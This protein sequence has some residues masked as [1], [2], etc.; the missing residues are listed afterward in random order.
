MDMNNN[1]EEGAHE[2]VIVRHHR[3]DHDEDHHGGVW[4]IAY[5]DFMT[6]MMAFFL[7]MWLI[8]A[9]DKKTVSQIA[10]YFNPLKLSDRVTSKKGVQEMA[11]GEPSVEHKDEKVKN[12][13]ENSEKASAEGEAKPEDHPE[14]T[15]KTLGGK[16]EGSTAD[17]I[18]S[19]Y[20]EQDLFK[21]PYN[22]LS[23]IASKA[24][25]EK[26]KIFGEKRA[27]DEK[28]HGGEAFRDPFDPDFRNAPTKGGQEMAK[29]APNIDPFGGT[30]IPR[31]GAVEG[32][33]AT[34]TPPAPDDS[35]V[36]NK[37]KDSET[38]RLETQLKQAVAGL[39]PGAMPN[40]E[41]RN[42]DEGKVI[43]LTDQ[44]DFGMFNIGSAEPKPELVTVMDK[45]GKI[46]AE[47]SGSVIVRG[48]TDGR[49]FKSGNYDN[50]RLSTARAQMAYHMLVRGGVPE[51]RFEAIQGFADRMLLSPKEPG[52]AQNR[53]IE[54][55]LR[56]VK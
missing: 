25:K 53:R 45:L 41:V 35:S 40:I 34:P 6:A 12:K 55:L 27:P 7:V 28:A 38:T 19:A 39:D 24:P 37:D 13:G 52:A 2:V 3:G 50:W 54:I 33:A 46:I 4:K 15:K 1:K 23:D 17:G 49:P 51:K 26:K 11:P 8:N 42:T 10:N 47:Q 5:A 21:D 18:R 36:K 30:V 14:K 32:P 16:L 44:F 31:G 43:S 22:I 9:A 48:H 56:K 29:V 20:A